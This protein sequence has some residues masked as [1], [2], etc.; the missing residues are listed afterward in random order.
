[1]SIRAS[2]ERLDRAMERTR[3]VVGR[4]TSAPSASSPWRRSSRVYG[5]SAA[6]RVYAS[7]WSPT[8]VVDD[9]Q[10]VDPRRALAR[11]RDDRRVAELPRPPPRRH[12]S[13]ARR[14]R[15]RL[16]QR[17]EQLAALVERHRVR[18]DLADVGERD[19]R[20]PDEAVVDRQDRLG[21]DR[22]RRVVQQVVRLVD[23]PDERALDREHAVRCTARPRP[24]R[25]RR[26][27]TAAA[28]RRAAGKSRSQAA[29]L[30][31]PSRPG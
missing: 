17:G 6:K 11:D 25:R 3:A 10:P 30:W 14:P 1:M 12:P 22:E 19:R 7:G 18:A 28:T 26:R 23:G 2:R 5:A 29:A 20:R 8:F 16:G 4:R 27:R 9:G 15:S 13:S 31:A 21:D 24:R